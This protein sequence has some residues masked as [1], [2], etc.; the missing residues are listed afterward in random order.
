MR[1][2]LDQIVALCGRRPTVLVVDDDPITIAILQML[3][4]AKADIVAASNHAA[5]LEQCHALHPDL[6]LLDINL[7]DEDGFELCRKLKLQEDLAETPV[8]FITGSSDEADEVRAFQLGA[9]DFIRKP[10]S[11][12]IAEARV[13]T[14]LSLQLQTEFLTHIAHSDGLTGLKNRRSFDQALEREWKE[15]SRTGLPLSL[16]MIDIDHFKRYNDIYG[17]L[18]GDTCLRKVA[19]VVDAALGRPA[20]CAAR[21]G[22]EEFGCVLPHTGFQGALTVAQKIRDN[23]GALKI[24]HSDGA[25]PAHTV[26]ASLGVATAFPSEAPDWLDLLQA[27]DQQLYQAKQHG[28]DRVCGHLRGPGKYVAGPAAGINGAARR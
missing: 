21:Y 14:H 5:A 2:K 16:V 10:L 17:H 3:F 1:E 8:I 12:F 9:V 19:E 7:G 22:G 18:A 25:N 23:I 28:R 11:P 20:D 26:S 4:E 15:C 13:L 27:A 6:I 24:A